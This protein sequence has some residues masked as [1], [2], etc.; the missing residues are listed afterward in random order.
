MS[1]NEL[2]TYTVGGVGGLVRVCRAMLWEVSFCPSLLSSST[3]IVPACYQKLL[4]V[5]RK[6]DGRDAIG[7]W[8]KGKVY[9]MLARPS[10]PFLLSSDVPD[11][12]LLIV[13]SSPLRF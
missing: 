1:R 13:R 9:H 11:A 5:W 6:D 7:R 10:T 4:R 3:D 8:L 12:I 2:V